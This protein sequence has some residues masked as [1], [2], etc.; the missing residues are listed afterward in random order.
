MEDSDQEQVQA[1][2]EADQTINRMELAANIVVAYVANN[3][4][5]VAELP[6]LIKTLHQALTSLGQPAAPVVEPIAK[7]TPAQIRKSITD[8][9]L[10][11]FI[12]GRPYKTLKRHLTSHGFHPRSYREHFGLPSDYPMV[13][14]SYVAARSALAKSIGLGRTQE[15]SLRADTAE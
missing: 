14:S 12:D 8:D 6:R 1:G 10:I 15:R 3:S 2:Y 13:T 11:S 4:V 9:A 7:S 5:P